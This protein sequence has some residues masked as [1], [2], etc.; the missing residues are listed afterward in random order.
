ML[1]TKMLI[2]WVLLC[3]QIEVQGLAWQLACE[4]MQMMQSMHGQMQPGQMGP[5]RMP[6]GQMQPK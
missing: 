2:V 6:P 5:G 4:T 1:M 3:R